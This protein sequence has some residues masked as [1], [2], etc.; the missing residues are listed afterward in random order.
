MSE[1]NVT[2]SV[3]GMTCANCAANIER[4]LNKKTSGVHEAG[5]N[6]A[7]ER[8]SVTYD[9]A[10]LSVDQIIA[11]VQK[12]GYGAAE[13][14]ESDAAGDA[15]TAARNAEI[16][17]QT[18]KFVIGAAFTLPLFVLSMGRDFGVLGAWSHAA[19]VNWLLFC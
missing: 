12:A 1:E 3:S 11:A 17:D 14:D 18:K 8:A 7:T 16:R 9:P 13:F 4:A 6:F 5:V 2:L 10:E 19:W 15:E